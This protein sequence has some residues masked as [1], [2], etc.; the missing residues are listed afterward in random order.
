[1]WLSGWYKILF[2][3]QPMWTKFLTVPNHKGLNFKLHVARINYGKNNLDLR[4][5]CHSV[6]QC[7]FYYQKNV[8]QNTMYS[9]NVKLHKT[10]ANAF[11]SRTFSFIMWYVNV[12]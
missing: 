4:S 10:K 2:H 8:K 11:N 12:S 5:L 7:S 9:R 1:M 6:T 3:C